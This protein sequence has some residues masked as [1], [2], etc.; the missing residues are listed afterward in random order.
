MM[1]R[2]N[3]MNY[4]FSQTYHDINPDNGFCVPNMFNDINGKLMKKLIIEYFTDLCFSVRGEV[5][6][7]KECKEKKKD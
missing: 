5:Y 4:N 1:K 7:M 6:P 2:A 3:V